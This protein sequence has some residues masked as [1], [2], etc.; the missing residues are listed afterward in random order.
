MATRRGTERRKASVEMDAAVLDGAVAV[1]RDAGPDDLNLSAVARAAGV[2]TGAVYARYENRQEL[3]LDVWEKRAAAQLRELIELVVQANDG[4]AQAAALAGTRLQARDPRPMVAVALMI[5]AVRVEELEEVLLP[6]V[7]A[8]FDPAAEGSAARE[9][10]VLVAFLLGALAFD[11]TLNAPPR[12]WSQPLLWASS[13]AVPPPHRVAQPDARQPDELLDL[14]PVDT[15][16]LVRDQLLQSMAVI[17]AKS[18]LKRATTS[19]IARAVGYQ[20][21]VVF[22][23]WP[24]RADLVTEFIGLALKGMVRTTS[25]LGAAALAGD[26]AGASR[27]LT[28]VLS[29]AYQRTR[30]LRLETVV[31]AMSD[32]HVAAIVAAQD[33]AAIAAMFGD[34][35]D[36]LVLVLAEAIRAVTLGLVLLEETVGGLAD[37][38]FTAP[39]TTLLSAARRP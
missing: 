14:I 16:D 35:P 24:T 33:S 28:R 30:R 18:G 38:D 10:I 17:V 15:G 3:L 20:Q 5:A 12:D 11:A 31:A 27:A 23:L 8:W 34:R 25:P 9:A 36:P 37:L 4:D 2:T 39:V 21:G 29:P 6:Q 26:A 1:I 19:R 32:P 13:Q 7:R 22:E